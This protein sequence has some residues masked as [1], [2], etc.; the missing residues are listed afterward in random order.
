MRGIAPELDGCSCYQNS[1]ER[2]LK[3]GGPIGIRS[4][5]LPQA[6]SEVHGWD[7]HLRAGIARNAPF[8]TRRNAGMRLIRLS[9]GSEKRGSR[10]RE[11]QDH[12]IRNLIEIN[13]LFVVV[14]ESL[15]DE[16]RRQAAEIERLKSDADRRSGF[17]A[18]VERALRR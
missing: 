13:S 1:L 2:W 6:A 7:R 11:D 18:V 16:V 8:F 10:V 3:L 15:I 5:F 9:T 17:R 12:A 4:C 14:I